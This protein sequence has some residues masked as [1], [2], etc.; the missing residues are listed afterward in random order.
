MDRR[1]F[2]KCNGGTLNL[3]GY[4]KTKAGKTDYNLVFDKKI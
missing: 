3:S 2:L 1:D 4:S